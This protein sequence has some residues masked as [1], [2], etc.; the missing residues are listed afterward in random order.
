MRIR[1][2]ARARPRFGYERITILL[3]SDFLLSSQVTRT[4]CLTAPFASFLD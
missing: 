2:L 1:E 3:R 4:A